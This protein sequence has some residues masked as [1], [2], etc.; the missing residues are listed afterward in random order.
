LEHNLVT[1]LARELSNG[2]LTSLIDHRV[3]VNQGNYV[4]AGRRP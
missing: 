4:N 1:H 3:T 2:G